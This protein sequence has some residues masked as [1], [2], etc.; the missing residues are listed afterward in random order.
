MAIGARVGMGMV[1][2]GT[3]VPS[4]QQIRLTRVG[5]GE[6]GRADWEQPGQDTG[7]PCKVLR[8]FLMP[9]ARL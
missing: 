8:S 2:R 9:G 4:P 7:L 6:R 3:G 5:Q 1:K